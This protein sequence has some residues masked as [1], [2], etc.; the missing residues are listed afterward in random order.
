MVRYA[1]VAT[2][3]LLKGESVILALI[4]FHCYLWKGI[5]ATVSGGRH[6]P[7]KEPHVCDTW[8]FWLRASFDRPLDMCLECPRPVSR[9]S[10][11]GEMHIPCFH[12]SKHINLFGD[13]ERFSNTVASLK[14]LLMWRSRNI[15]ASLSPCSEIFPVVVSCKQATL[16]PFPSIHEG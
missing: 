6:S 12:S 15:L 5:K 9:L 4:P 8:R 7:S 1:E 14:I 10:P 2:S 13:G 11:C 3:G 16:P